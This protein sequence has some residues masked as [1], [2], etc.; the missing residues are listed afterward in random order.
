MPSPTDPLFT[1]LETEKGTRFSCIIGLLGGAASLIYYLEDHHSVALALLAFFT[2]G[3]LWTI[4][5]QIS[6]RKKARPK[7]IVTNGLKKVD[8]FSGTYSSIIFVYGSLLVKDSLL[9]TVCKTPATLEC[10]PVFLKHHE[11]SWGAISPRGNYLNKDFTAVSNED[12]WASLVVTPSTKRD[13]KVAGAL[14][15]VSNKEKNALK[16]RESNYKLVNVT[17]QIL[18]MGDVTI[19]EKQ[20]WTFM[21][22]EIPPQQHETKAYVREKYFQ[23]ISD[24]LSSLGHE[25]LVPPAHYQLRESYLIAEQV[26]RCLKGSHKTNL[27]DLNHSITR[28]IANKSDQHDHRGY[29]LWPLIVS[30]QSYSEIQS[31]AEAAVRL[32]SQALRIIH[33]NNNLLE[34]GGYTNEDKRF[35][36]HSIKTDTLLPQIARVDLAISGNRLLVLEVNSDSPGGMQHLDLISSVQAE[37]CSMDTNFNWVDCKSYST[38][39]EIMKVLKSAGHGLKRGAIVEVDPEPWPT[40]PE[41]QFFMQELTNT[42]IKSQIVDLNK[43]HFSIR[44]DA[45]YVDNEALPID[46]LYKRVLWKDL[47]E[48]YKDTRE[49]IAEAFLTD[50]VKIINS[51][52]A[53]MSGNKLILALLKSPAFI[54][55][56]RN[57]SLISDTEEAML[58]KNFPET[59]I[60]GDNPL[61][62]G[63][64]SLWKPTLLD[65]YQDYVLKSYHGYAGRDV[66]TGCENSTRVADFKEKWNDSYIIQEFIPHGRTLIPVALHESRRISWEHHYYILGAY[67]ING[68]CVAIEA[69]T[70][71]TLP[72]SMREAHRTAVYP[73]K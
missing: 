52:G 36:A 61:D 29:A 11:L 16:A 25:R 63:R 53:R 44:N 40:Y 7:H 26:E 33:D 31:V 58:S 38:C 72:I 21:P 30:K 41:M 50:K 37:A 43:H 39:A 60:W 55:E 57:K 49:A 67:V 17:Q 3:T 59:H 54:E 13:S 1:F 23:D 19:P 47:N 70:Q 35:L 10:I 51:L 34:L 2:L 15:G 8:R 14:I 28:K 64:D 62:E 22:K 71:A 9:M 46:L 5:K 32:S 27:D 69:K 66:I 20:I 12:N 68:R 4:T 65:N 73:T 48:T 56:M 6:I 18:P 45:L 24:A 42:G